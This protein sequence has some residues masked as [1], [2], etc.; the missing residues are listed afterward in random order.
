MSPTRSLSLSLEGK[1]VIVTGAARGIGEGI[2]R[3]F[4]H[5]ECNVV[6][7][8]RMRR[9]DGRKRCDALADDINRAGGQAFV[10]QVDI[11]DRGQVE[12]MLEATV[13]KFGRIHV[14]VNNADIMKG[15]SLIDMDEKNLQEHFDVNI[16]GCFNC[17]QLVAKQM[18]KQGT[19]GRIII[20]SSIDGIEAEEGI[21]AYSSSK[22]SLIMMA[23]CMAVELAS[24]KINVNTIAP[25]WVETDMT[26]PYLNEE[27]M[28]ELKRR[29]PLGYIAKPEEIAG[30]ALF[31]ASPLADYV[32]GQVLVI[33]G[34][35][36]SNITIKAS[37][38][39]VQY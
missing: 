23:K 20:I 19:G 39:V 32:T 27:L 33:D 4:G 5:S 36:T 6:I 24:H 9:S 10:M 15:G 37:Q 13:E 11:S 30:G 17:C 35:L 7:A 26:V 28:K 3:A 34:G 22:A 1:V 18:I 8:D 16:K 14:F 25:G 38:G 21:V 12:R 31:L 29:I 2:A